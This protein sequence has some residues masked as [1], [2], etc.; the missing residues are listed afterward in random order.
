M[1]SNLRF[2]AMFLFLLCAAAVGQYLARAGNNEIAPARDHLSAFPKQFGE[3]R[4]IDE[5]T[6]GPGAF[7]ELQPDD[8]ISR[9]YVDDRGVPV[10]LS[11]AYYA[12]QRHRKTFHSPQ[13]CL[14]GAGW[15]MGNHRL[16]GVDG[17]PEA[18]INEYLIGKDG[19]MMLAFYWY[20]GRGRVVASDYL[21]RIYT[22]KDSMMR[23]RTDGALV[24]VIAPMG[25]GEGA[26]EFAR[27]TGLDF[28]AKLLPMLSRY[29]PE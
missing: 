8:Y 21:G 3:W 19:A 24:R 14:P 5:Q 26:E 11:I 9:T 7:R 2:I 4:Q 10:Y 1:S 23:G 12:S 17:M 29:A 27:K 20:H 6:L 28:A 18:R 22:I 25:K 15:T 13:N 16:H